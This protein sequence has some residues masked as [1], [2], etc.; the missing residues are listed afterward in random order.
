M[1]KELQKG[2]EVQNRLETTPV[3][4][5]RPENLPHVDIYCIGPAGFHRAAKQ[6]DS[7]VFVTSL[8]EIDRI[9]EDREIESIWEDLAQQELTNKDLIE[10]KLPR[11]F[12][13]LK[14]F[15]SK[16]ASDVLA[17]HRSYDLKIELEKDT[18]D[19]GFSPLRHH[20][21]EELKACKQYLVDN[22]SK[23]FIGESQAPFAAPILFAQK[24]NGGLRFCVD[25]RNLNAIT[26]K[27]RYPIPLLEETLAR[28][29]RAR[30]FT[31]LDIR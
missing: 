20:T 4:M 16:A 19:L 13:D 12:S 21:L 14:D 8:Y 18:A 6:P 15:F 29:S 31:K 24:A 30:I 2:P 7:T 28:I 17:P 1:E 26:C 11:Q 23:G 3:R 22:L 5:K 25:Y 27:D 9:I 10:Q